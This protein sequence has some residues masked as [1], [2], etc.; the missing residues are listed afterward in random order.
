ME[1]LRGQLVCLIIKASR[2]SLL[3]LFFSHFIFLNA[4]HFKSKWMGFFPNT[5]LP[6]NFEKY[7]LEPLS[8]PGKKLTLKKM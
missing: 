7:Y 4:E 8:N 3:F 1:K 6:S 2:Y 5:V